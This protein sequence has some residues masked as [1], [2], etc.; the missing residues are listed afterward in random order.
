MDGWILPSFDKKPKSLAF[1]SHGIL[2]VTWTSCASV[3]V[4]TNHPRRAQRHRKDLRFLDGAILTA[5]ISLGLFRFARPCNIS[6]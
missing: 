1:G 6:L 5:A 2:G 4:Q 3:V